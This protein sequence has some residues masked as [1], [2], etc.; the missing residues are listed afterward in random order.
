MLEGLESDSEDLVLGVLLHDIGKP[1]TYEIRDR[2]TFYGHVPLGA[3]M[4]ED[5]CRRLH[6]SNK[7]TDS[8]TDLVAQHLRFIDVPNM[9]QSTLRRFLSQESFEKHMELHRLDCQASHG[10]LSIHEFCKNKLEEFRQEEK[11]LRPEPLLNGNDLI[12]MGLQ[13]GP[14]FSEMLKRVEDAQLEEEIA[15]TAEAKQLIRREFQDAFPSKK[16]KKSAS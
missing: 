1:P 3:A 15:T 4:A 16:K 14:L 12:A 13:P 11:L 2:I 6:C 9:R 7:L 5:I 8:V 10:D